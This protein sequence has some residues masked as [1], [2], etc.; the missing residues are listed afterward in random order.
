MLETWLDFTRSDATD[1]HVVQFGADEC[2]SSVNWPSDVTGTGW[3]R[4][5]RR[6][7]DAA[8]IRKLR[9]ELDAAHEKVS[10][11]TTQLNTNVSSSRSLILSVTS[12]LCPTNSVSVFVQRCRLALCLSVCLFVR[13]CF[14]RGVQPKCRPTV[15]DRKMWCPKWR[16]YFKKSG[17][18]LTLLLPYVTF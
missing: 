16:F 4:W 18:S 10:T 1:C 6:C 12:L 7:C 13:V 15:Q 3:W 17:K 11:L 5:V 8:Q 14:K 9:R 2:C